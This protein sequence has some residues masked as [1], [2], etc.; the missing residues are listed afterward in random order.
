MTKGSDYAAFVVSA[1][2]KEAVGNRFAE[3]RNKKNLL[4]V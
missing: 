2:L 1:Y 3:K 4:D